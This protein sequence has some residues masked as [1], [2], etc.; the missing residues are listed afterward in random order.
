MSGSPTPS[1]AAPVSAMNT[2]KLRDVLNG[3]S[4]LLGSDPVTA[5]DPDHVAFISSINL[6]LKRAWKHDFWPEWTLCE[7]RPFRDTWTAIGY[8][9]GAQVYH[10]GTAKYWYA[11]SD[12]II[13]GYATSGTA[14]PGVSAKWL[15]L[16]GFTRYVARKQAGKTVIEAVN[17]ICRNNPRLYPQRPGELRFDV[18]DLG[19]I[20]DARAGD[21]VWVEFRPPTPRFTATARDNAVVYAVG[22]LVYDE[23][24]GDCFKAL[25]AAAGHAVTDAAWWQKVDFPEALESFVVKASYADALRGDGQTAKALAESSNAELALIQAHDDAFAGQGQYSTASR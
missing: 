23:A 13:N 5:G 18:T 24:A 21:L 11:S 7:Q 6:H 1:P 15:P 14:V 12:T 25:Q 19:Y 8:V 22:D 3:I 9:Y 4:G 10:T 20:P 17:R 2:V 16:S